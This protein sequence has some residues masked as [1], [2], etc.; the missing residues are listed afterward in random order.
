MATPRVA[1]LVPSITETVLAW[2]VMPVAVTRFCEQPTLL[3]V[4]GTKD[5]DIDAIVELRPDVVVVDTEENRREDADAL[6]AAGVDVHVTAVRSV[7]DVAVA[8]AALADRL[9]LDP[10]VDLMGRVPGSGAE[11]V[12]PRVRAFIPIWRKPWM[13]ISGATYGTSL[14]AAAGVA[15][16]FADSDDPYPETTLDAAA[17]LGPDVVLAP[18]EPFPFGPRHVD[19]LSV[20]APVVLVDGQDLFWWGVRTPAALARLRSV[21]LRPGH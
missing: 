5:P 16:V 2:G 8:L 9:G 18:S 6:T 17:A 19:E 1:S 7:A 21:N 12:A 10:P 11:P 20:V 13:T 14:L 3:A 15:N 4:G